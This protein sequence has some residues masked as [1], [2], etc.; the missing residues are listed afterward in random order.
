MT[1]NTMEKRKNNRQHKRCFLYAIVLSVMFSLCHCVV[2]HVFFL[3]L[4]CLSC[5]LFAIVLSVM[6]S[7]CHCVVCHVFFMPLCCLSCF[8]YAIV[9]SVILKK[10]WQT[11]QWHKENM[12]DNTM[13]KRKHDRQHNGKKK[14]WQTTQ[15]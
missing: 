12:T 6:F 9:L 5:F 3:P 14:T 8:L 13:V 7:F 10:K 15:W 2:C 11:T 1:D 4:C